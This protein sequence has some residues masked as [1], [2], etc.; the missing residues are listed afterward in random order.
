MDRWFILFCWVAPSPQV[1]FGLEHGLPE[2]G[3]A[4]AERTLHEFLQRLGEW[5]GG[6]DNATV[7]VSRLPPRTTVQPLSFTFIT[8]YINMHMDMCMCMCMCM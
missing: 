3:D 1:E 6:K 7:Q 5:E 8:T 4:T 2:R